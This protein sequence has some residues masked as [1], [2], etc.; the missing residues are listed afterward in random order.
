M[1]SFSHLRANWKLAEVLA[2]TF[3]GLSEGLLPAAGEQQHSEMF[4]HYMYIQPSVL[5]S[6]RSEE[7]HF[8]PTVSSSWGPQVPLTSVA[9]ITFLNRG[10]SSVAWNMWVAS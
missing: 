9:N 6:V 1:S 7:F 8:Q 5:S 2:E 10:Q 3:L 4:S